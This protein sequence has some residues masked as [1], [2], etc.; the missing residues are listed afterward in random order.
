MGGV[1]CGAEIPRFNEVRPDQG[2]ANTM[3]GADADASGEFA[4]RLFRVGLK[5]TQD[6]VVSLRPIRTL[7]HG[8]RTRTALSGASLAWTMIWATIDYYNIV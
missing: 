5:Q 1:R 8:Y 7:R 4:L 6:A 2:L 3:Q